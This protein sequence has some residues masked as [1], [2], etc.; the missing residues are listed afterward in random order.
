M[1]VDDAGQHQQ[2]GR[3]QPEPGPGRSAVAGSDPV[4]DDGDI[5]LDQPLG[6]KRKAV[7]DVDRHVRLPA[8][9]GSLPEPAP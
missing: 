8:R 6:Q 3:I 9:L 2:A 4:V 1:A 5:G 7:L